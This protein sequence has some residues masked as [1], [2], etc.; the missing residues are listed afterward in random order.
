MPRSSQENPVIRTMGAHQSVRQFKS[1]PIEEAQVQAAV[2][3]AQRAATSSNIQA[4]SVLQICN[5]SKR[6][7]LMELC[8]NQ[9]Q[10]QQAGAFF[11]ICADQHRNRMVG[12]QHGRTHQAN[13]ETFLLAVTDAALFAQNLALA[14]ESMGLGTCFIGALRRDLPAVDQLLELP[15]DVMPLYGLCVG[16]PASAPNPDPRPRLPL[17]A[18]YARDE[19]P[20]DAVLRQLIDEHDADI[21][22]W[23]ERTGRPG[24]HWSGG[25]ARNFEQ[26]ARGGILAYYESKGARFR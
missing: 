2:R 23:Y 6:A 5:P 8:G 25:V 3:A 7:T 11:V 15:Q 20:E 17:E 4:Y 19:Y 14:F 26:P 16:A 24:Y 13:L 9:A 18:I 21:G 10:I 22:G 1:E 12:E